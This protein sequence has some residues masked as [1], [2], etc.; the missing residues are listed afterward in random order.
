M[1][2]RRSTADETLA[3][4]TSTSD[5]GTGSETWPFSMPGQNEEAVEY[6]GRNSMGSTQFF[7][8]GLVPYDLSS[9]VTSSFDDQDLTLSMNPFD[10]QMNAYTDAD[11]PPY[12][13]QIE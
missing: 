2:P 9:Q 12:L 11:I 13:A 1:N 7:G 5:A 3:A 4:T 10:L 8:D 6:S